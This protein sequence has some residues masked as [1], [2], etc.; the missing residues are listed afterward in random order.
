MALDGQM[1][2]TQV[3][4]A[5]GESAQSADLV[6]YAMP[7]PGEERCRWADEAIHSAAPRKINTAPCPFGWKTINFGGL[8]GLHWSSIMA[9]QSI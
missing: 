5:Q 2:A 1:L 3:S 8:H 6:Q 7:S 4:L 9:V